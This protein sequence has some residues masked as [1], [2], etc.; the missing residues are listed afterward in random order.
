M[1]RVFLAIQRDKKVVMKKGKKL[2]KLSNSTTSDKPVKFD[3]HKKIK[4]ATMYTRTEK[5]LRGS[6]AAHG[7]GFAHSWVRLRCIVI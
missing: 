1:V 3:Q 5:T 6:H 2:Q 7:P 4:V